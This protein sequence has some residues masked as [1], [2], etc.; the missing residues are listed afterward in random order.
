MGSFFTAQF[1]YCPLVWMDCSREVNNKINRLHKSRLV[2]YSD[3]HSTFKE[4]LTKI[5]RSRFIT[6]I[7]KN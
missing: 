1:G 2:V 6:E 4:L 3:K 7:L 5:N